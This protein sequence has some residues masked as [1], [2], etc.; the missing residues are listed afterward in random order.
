MCSSDLRIEKAHPTPD[1]EKERVEKQSLFVIEPDT[2]LAGTK[3]VDP[4]ARLNIS[5][6]GAV[7]QFINLRLVAKQAEYPWA[8]RKN[9]LAGN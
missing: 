5:V 3:L 2:E 6:S 1:D 4:R 8:E 7:A 9:P